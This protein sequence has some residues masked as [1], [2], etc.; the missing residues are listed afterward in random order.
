[1]KRENLHENMK[2]TEEDGVHLVLIYETSGGK[3]GLQSQNRKRL[4]APDL[5][6]KTIKLQ[7]QQYSSTTTA[8]EDFSGSNDNFSEWQKNILKKWSQ[9]FPNVFSISKQIGR[10]FIFF[11]YKVYFEIE[12]L[13]EEW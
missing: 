8:F 6:E 5:H 7:Q 9:I 12:L 1:M 13:L 2:E 11:W 4:Y 3:C 10:R